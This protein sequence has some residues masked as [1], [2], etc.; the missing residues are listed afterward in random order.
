MN[1]P[2]LAYKHVLTP[3]EHDIMRDVMAGM[4]AW[5]SGEARGT[6]KN[7]V[8]TQRQRILL[9]LGAKNA[10]EAVAIYLSERGDKWQ[11]TA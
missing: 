6:S 8:R 7:T 10:A 3:G 1:D 11:G 2:G 4:T 9:K 5:E